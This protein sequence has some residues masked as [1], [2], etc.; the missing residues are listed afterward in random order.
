MH[1]FTSSAVFTLA[2]NCATSVLMPPLPPTWISQPESTAMMPTSLMPDSAQLRGQPDTASFTL[3]GLHMLA[4]IVSRSMPICV[5]FWVPKRQ[6]SLPTQV[7]TVRIDF[8]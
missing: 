5:L 1:S 4:S 3:C 2:R 8:P 7:F 6:N